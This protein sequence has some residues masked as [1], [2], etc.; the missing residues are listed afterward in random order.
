MAVRCG[1]HRSVEQ[2]RPVPHLVIHV[3]LGWKGTNIGLG[4]CMLAHQL[5]PP[6]QAS[7]A[8]FLTNGC[9]EPQIGALLDHRC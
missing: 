2:V 7:Q 1:R 6:D 5:Q 3:H 4:W 9:R 8:A